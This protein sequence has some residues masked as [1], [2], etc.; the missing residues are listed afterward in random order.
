MTHLTWNAFLSYRVLPGMLIFFSAAGAA[1]Y[2][3]D[4]EEERKLPDPQDVSFETADNVTIK[5][6]YWEPLKP[7]KSTVPII[8]LH[9]WEGKRTDYDVLGRTLQEQFGHAVLSID[10]RGHGGSTTQKIPNADRDRKIELDKMRKTDFQAMVADVHAAKKFL[11]G[12]HKREEL[13]IELLTIVGADMGAIVALQYA[14]YDWR[15]QRPVH[16]LYKTSQD[17]RGLVLLSPPKSFK[18]LTASVA[19]QNPVVRG[20]VGTMII[21]GA[22]DRDAYGDARSLYKSLENYHVRIPENAKQEE[23]EEKQDL[24][25][26]EPQTTLQGTKLLARALKTDLIIAK[27]VDLRLVKKASDVPWR[28]RN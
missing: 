12:K 11:V 22:D 28:E 21:V 7:G 13:N 15:P 20:Q 16:P 14:A 10:L 3:Q 9:G 8:L 17:V 2:A 25:F 5:A 27:F 6:T 4:E 24:F 26:I 18:G 1:L 19:L 23:K